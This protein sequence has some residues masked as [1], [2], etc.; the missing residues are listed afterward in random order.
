MKLST[1][2]ISVLSLF[3]LAVSTLP[4]Q[5]ASNVHIINDTAS[6]AYKNGNYQLSDAVSLIIHISEIIL[7]IVGVLTF[8]M[9]VYGGFLFLMSSGNTETVKKAKKIIIAAIIGLI[10]VFTSYTLVQFF[11]TSITTP[12][13]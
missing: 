7:Q 9:F 10:I 4:V 13:T 12:T 1:I 3:L 8:A 5:A 6:D 2:K 11:I